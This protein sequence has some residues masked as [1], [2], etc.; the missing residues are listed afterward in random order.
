PTSYFFSSNFQNPQVHEFDFSIQRELFP[1][2]TAQVSYMGALG[3]ELPN[4]VNINLNPNAN[5]NTAPGSQPNGVI[6]SVITFSDA[7]GAGRLPNGAVYVVPTYSKTNTST[8]ANLLN[9]NFGAVNELMSNINSSY[10]ALVAEIQNKSSKRIQYDV[11]YTWSH[12]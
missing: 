6:E 1:G 9:P 5:T 4:A 3:R 2:V 8:T 10:N 12:A 11:N 7:A